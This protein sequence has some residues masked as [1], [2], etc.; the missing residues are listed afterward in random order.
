MEGN[1]KVLEKALLI[2]EQISVNPQGMTMTELSQMLGIP[3]SSVHGLLATFANMG[4]LRK[5]QNSGRFFMGLKSFELGMK[6]VD[7]NEFYR[8]SRDVLETLVGST[9]ETAH[10]AILE[11]RDVVYISK[12][13]CAHAVRMISHIGK[14]IPAHATAIGKALLSGK[15]DDEIRLLYANDPLPRITDNTICDPDALLEQ[16]RQA[17]QS[18]FALEREEST[19]GVRCIAVPVADRS[20][21]VVAA[22]SISVPLLR[23]GD[24][25]ERFKQPLTDAKYRM[26]AVV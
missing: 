7:N 16:V 5:E 10:M 17:R 20:G 11:G 22:I 13:D 25:F 2:L 26:Q 21:A 24:D 15:T 8:Y 4:Y 12:F 14:R 6:F 23:W 18:G 9:G 19:P 3:K 1:H